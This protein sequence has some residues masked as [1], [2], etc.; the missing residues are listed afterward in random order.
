M[1]LNRLDEAK[2]I[3]EQAFAEG[4]DSSVLHGSRLYWAFIVEDVSIQ[5]TEIAWFQSHP[6]PLG[7]L[8][9]A[10]NAAARGQ[11]RRAADW[12][13]EGERLA[14]AAKSDVDPGRVRLEMAT[15]DALFGKCPTTP[16]GVAPAPPIARA[17]CG[18]LPTA[19]KLIDQS[20]RADV[21][22]SI[23]PVAFLQ[24]QVML[25]Q[26]HAKEA[27]AAFDAI[28]NQKAVNW[29]AVYAAAHVGLAR[30]ASLAGDTARARRAYESFFALWKDADPDVPLL[31]A[32]RKEY[33]K[34]P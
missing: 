2:G 13:R 22:A 15:N 3:V 33:A 4:L 12:Y 23:G 30:A 20:A 14:R 6:D 10:T 27:A 29:G 31:V 21:P 26:G 34:L 8:H 7:V 24:A 25:S 17:L 18:H 1:A 11:D 28:L 19:Q 32:A 5:T 16:S 9:Q